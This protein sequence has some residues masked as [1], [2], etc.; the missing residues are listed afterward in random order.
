VGEKKKHTHTHTQV[1][2]LVQK[3]FISRSRRRRRRR[4][5]LFKPKMIDLQNIERG[6]TCESSGR[7][8][9]F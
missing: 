8:H 1:K 9:D 5:K 6:G 3:F 7:I 2:K 4:I